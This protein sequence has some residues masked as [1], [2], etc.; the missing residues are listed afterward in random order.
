MKGTGNRL[1]DK[2]DIFFLLLVIFFALVNIITLAWF[3]NVWIDEV[4]FTDPAANYVS[5]RGLTSTVWYT[6]SSHEFW[7]GNLPLHVYL[8][9]PWLKVFGVSIVSERSV[10]VFYFVLVSLMLWYW[11]KITDYIKGYGLCVLFIAALWLG[12]LS[13]TYRNGRSDTL[14]L[15]IA[16]F[17][18]LAFS[19]QY[20]KPLAFIGG[21]FSI[22]AGLQLPPYILLILVFFYL[23]SKTQRSQILRFGLWYVCGVSLGFLS[24]LLFL[25]QKGLAGIILTQ[26]FGSGV[27]ITGDIAQIVVTHS[28]LAWARLYIKLNALAHFY[29]LYFTDIATTLLTCY[30]VFI[31]VFYWLGK[32]RDSLTQLLSALY[33]IVPIV[34]LALGRFPVHYRWMSYL[35]LLFAVFRAMQSAHSKVVMRI[36]VIIVLF[37]CVFGL[38]AKLGI[39]DKNEKAQQQLSAFVN[40][41][42]SP[43]DIVYGDYV[44]YFACRQ[45]ARLFYSVGYAGG[46]N[47]PIMPEREKASVSKLLIKPISFAATVKKLGGSW[48]QVAIFQ[49][50]DLVLYERMV[51]SN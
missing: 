2:K 20:K 49:P 28:E 34:M 51:S 45:R 18:L 35:V 42:I 9:I 46:R 3:P 48:Q 38:P 43:S 27:A 23:V 40:E 31:N 5:G 37:S 6:Q 1:I 4:L 11:V 47:F 29:Q 15:F 16:V 44:G 13:V 30:L 50:F 41:N 8:L 39:G 25:Y 26:T 7:T 10:S 32:K 17:C 19:S 36:G 24:L 21:V 33:F 22:L 12:Q 14:T